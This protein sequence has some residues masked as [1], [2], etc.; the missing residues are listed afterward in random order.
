[1]PRRPTNAPPKAWLVRLLMRVKV[2][3]PSSSNR[4]N[5]RHSL[6]ATFSRC[7]VRTSILG[8]LHHPSTIEARARLDKHIKIETFHQTL[9]E[10]PQLVSAVNDLIQ[11]SDIAERQLSGHNGQMSTTDN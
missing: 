4:R 2:C 6:Y 3:Q 11:P 7:L 9:Y 8:H 10:Q 1:M 5:L